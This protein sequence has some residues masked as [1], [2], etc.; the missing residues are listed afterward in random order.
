MNLLIRA[1]ATPEIGMGHVM[2]CLALAQAWRSIKV[3]KVSFT[4]QLDIALQRIGQEGF[5]L[6]NGRCSAISDGDWTVVDG[7]HLGD[8][9]RQF[10]TMGFKTLMVDDNCHLPEYHADIILN[11]N[12]H[13]ESLHSEYEVKAPGARLLLGFR[14]ALLR[15]EFWLYREWRR[16]IPD[17]ATKV[18][19]TFGDSDM[20][21]KAIQKVRKA[22]KHLKG[23]EIRESDGK[24][25]M[26]KLMA[27]AD[28]AV[29]PGSVTAM[30]C[31]F[32]GLP[33]IMLNIAEN[34][35]QNAYA[36]TT[37]G[38]GVCLGN[39]ENT[40][41]GLIGLWVDSLAH[42]RISRE[43]M[44]QA[45]RSLVDGKGAQRVVEAMA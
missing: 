30:E 24:T 18:L 8:I 17:T 42:N 12:A 10:Q 16:K 36:L 41:P 43:R 15:Q 21:Q 14:Y 39:L 31:A 40:T 9:A 19:I 7:Y 44:S 2:R 34:Q 20:A 28:L 23:L 13:A 5:N 22:L 1:D 3:G 27:W 25:P 6:S 38:V 26:P 29:C 45:G 11:H 33:T 37:A 4:G 32:M 35:V